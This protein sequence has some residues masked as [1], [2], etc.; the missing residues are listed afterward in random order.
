MYQSNIINNNNNN[1]DPYS[2][3][4]QQQQSTI[5]SFTAPSSMYS[6]PLHSFGAM[7]SSNNSNII[8]SCSRAT[9]L[10][11]NEQLMEDRI[12]QAIREAI[13]QSISR[14]SFSCF[15]N[16]NSMG[17]PT[18]MTTN[19]F[20]VCERERLEN[21][22]GNVSF[23]FAAVTGV[24]VVKLMQ[25]LKKVFGS[26]IVDVT[27]DASYLRIMA[28]ITKAVYDEQ[29]YADT[30]KSQTRHGINV[31]LVKDALMGE[32]AW[33]GHYEANE[34]KNTTVTSS[35]SSDDSSEFSSSSS[36]DDEE[37]EGRTKTILGD[38]KGKSWFAQYAKYIMP[39]LT[40]VAGGLVPRVFAIF[41][42]WY[43]YSTEGDGNSDN[44]TTSLPY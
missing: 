24:D 19:L 21:P 34:T 10:Y 32:T 6:S 20:G 15:Y 26:V 37:K 41:H 29:Q 2:T 25:V 30:A 22:S 1:L 39:L 43:S 13:T 33:R 40:I 18:T 23:N 4:L 8:N 36:V 5:P 27:I 16:D 3:P 12:E 38:K 31:G 42:N 9:T 11:Q 35:S 28:N 14:A 17:A 7:M 44:N